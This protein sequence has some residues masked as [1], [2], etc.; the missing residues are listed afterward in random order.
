MVIGADTTIASTD[1]GVEVS[2]SGLCGA[3]Q[4]L[5]NTCVGS[6]FGDCCGSGGYCGSGSDYCGIGN[7]QEG[8]CDGDVAYSTDGRCGQD[9]DY[10][11]CPPKFGACC[12]AYGKYV[13][14][15]RLL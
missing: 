3:Q 11:E 2:S 12:S 10:L 15:Y 6:G 14:S 13:K 5:T 8:D 4:N 1:R 9:F 7:C